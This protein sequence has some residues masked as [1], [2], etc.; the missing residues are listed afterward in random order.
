M[1]KVLITTVPFGQRDRK[2]IEI[3]ESL[4]VE[5][6]Y[7]EKCGNMKISFQDVSSR[8]SNPISKFIHSSVGINH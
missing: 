3:L 7:R 8:L 6:C 4:S 2:P 1:H 5:I